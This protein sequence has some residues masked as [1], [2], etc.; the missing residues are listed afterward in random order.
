MS[1]RIIINKLTQKINS[2]NLDLVMTKLINQSYYLLNYT[3]Q[4]INKSYNIIEEII[5]KTQS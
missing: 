3:Y 5:N 1:I 4:K 2:K